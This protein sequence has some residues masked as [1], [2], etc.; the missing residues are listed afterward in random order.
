MNGYLVSLE[1]SVYS[2]SHLNFEAEGK[3]KSTAVPQTVV[4]AKFSSLG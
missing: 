2:E 1:Y 4:L 3:I